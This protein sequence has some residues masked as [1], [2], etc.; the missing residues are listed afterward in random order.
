MSGVDA[1]LLVMLV[2]LLVLALLALK[3]GVVLMLLRQAL[4]GALSGVTT[5]G[6]PNSASPRV[7]M[8][9]WSLP[10][11]ASTSA[12]KGRAQ[13]SVQASVRRSHSSRP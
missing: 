1:G 2:P 8:D 7:R 5:S 6:S 9:S 13:G 12:R 3:M 11:A 4:P 10:S